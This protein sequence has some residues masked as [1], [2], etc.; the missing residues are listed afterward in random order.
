M[1]DWF[2]T[3]MLPSS[4]CA[5]LSSRGWKARTTSPRFLTA[6]VPDGSSVWPFICTFWEMWKAK[7]RQRPY[8]SV[9]APSSASKVQEAAGSSTMA[10]AEVSACRCQLYRC[11]E[12]GLGHPP[13]CRFRSEQGG[14]VLIKP[15]SQAWQSQC[16]PGE[17]PSSP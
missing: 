15:A 4:S 7:V 13:V 16:G 8:F 1:K 12:A 6:K 10:L 17:A 9:A 14:L 5:H 3:H 2:S 11:K